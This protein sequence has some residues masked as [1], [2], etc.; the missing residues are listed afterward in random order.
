[1]FR[2]RTCRRSDNEAVTYFKRSSRDILLPHCRVDIA[3]MLDCI[4]G[5]PHGQPPMATVVPFCTW[6]VRLC[7]RNEVF[8]SNRHCRYST[9]DGAIRV[10]RLQR[11]TSA[12]ACPGY[13]RIEFQGPL[14]QFMRNCKSKI[15]LLSTFR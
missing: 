4:Q 12:S 8:G 1:M 13:V 7:P 5:C 9:I 14:P 2:L 11:R 10:L 15:N 3:R 6:V